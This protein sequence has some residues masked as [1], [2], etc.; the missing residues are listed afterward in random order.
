MKAASKKLFHLFRPRNRLSD[1]FSLTTIS[2]LSI[3]IIIID[4]GNA[5]SSSKQKNRTLYVGPIAVARKIAHRPRCS[6]IE[7][8]EI[9]TDE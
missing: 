4:F 2:I 5:A 9:R 6:P 8:L 1:R 3:I 7:S